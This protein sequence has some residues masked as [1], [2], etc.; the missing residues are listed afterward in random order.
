MSFH[1]DR[2][3][4]EPTD[5]ARSGHAIRVLGNLSLICA[6]LVLLGSL[7]FGTTRVCGPDP[8]LG[9]TG[10]SWREGVACWAGWTFLCGLLS[11]GSLLLATSSVLAGHR[12][13]GAAMAALPV[14][15]LAFAA[16]LAGRNWQRLLAER[17]RE[18]DYVLH[19][20]AGLPIVTLAASA[21]TLLAAILAI[22]ILMLRC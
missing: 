14:P 11:L 18:R 19:I 4:R 20:A 21:G 3:R 17:D 2:A 10:S 8:A 5:R 13:I 6:A 7:A 9:S 16:F 15:L 1:S 12:R 22:A